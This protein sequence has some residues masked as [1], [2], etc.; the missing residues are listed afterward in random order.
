LYGANQMKCQTDITN[1]AITNNFNRI[2]NE[3]NQ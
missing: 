3:N 1:K 2:V